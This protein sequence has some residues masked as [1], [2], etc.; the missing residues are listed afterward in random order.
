MIVLPWYYCNSWPSFKDCF[1]FPFYKYCDPFQQSQK[2]DHKQA[3]KLWNVFISSLTI[4]SPLLQCCLLFYNLYLLF[5]NINLL[6]YSVISSF[7]IFISPLLQLYLLF[8]NIVS[9]FTIVSPLLQCYLLFY[10]CI[11]SF[12]VLSPLLQY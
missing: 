10:N 12:T 2:G 7:T 9:S 5:Y 8:Y 11:S 1:Q 4:L 3:I 6:F